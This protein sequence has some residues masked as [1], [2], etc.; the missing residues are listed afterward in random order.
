VDF[1]LVEYPLDLT[2]FHSLARQVQNVPT[3]VTRII[4]TCGSGITAIYVA[5]GVLWFAPWVRELVLISTGYNKREFI[6]QSARLLV[7]P[8]MEAPLAH[9]LRYISLSDVTSFRY[10]SLHPVTLGG[11][12]LHAL[13][14]AK[15]FRWAATAGLLSE[16]TLFWLTAGPDGYI[17]P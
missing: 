12:N 1:G 7:G 8:G 13:Y 4:L 10:D 3:F 17:K 9:L 6:L 11:I 14:E 16:S 2:F 15:T 5:C